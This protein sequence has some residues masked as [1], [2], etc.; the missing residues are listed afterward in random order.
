MLQIKRAYLPAQKDDGFRIL[1]DRLW[2]RG[3]SKEKE[4][5]GLWAKDI[6]PST[7]IRKEFGHIPGNF[8]S[9]KEKYLKELQSNA[10]MKDF[11]DTITGKLKQGNV[12]LIYG[13][14]DETY[15]HAVVLRDFILK[16]LD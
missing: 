3:M 7:Q 8:P 11:L 9:F 5:V 10:S 2:P 16:K 15:N 6:A 1:V 13:A 4:A 12:T 14:K